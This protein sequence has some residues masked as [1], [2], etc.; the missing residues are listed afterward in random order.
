MKEWGRCVKGGM[1]VYRHSGEITQM[2]TEESPAARIKQKA[3]T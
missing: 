1:K 3:K 2:R